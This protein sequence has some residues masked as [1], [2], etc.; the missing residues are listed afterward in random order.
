MILGKLYP[1]YPLVTTDEN[2]SSPDI[3]GYLEHEV[4]LLVLENLQ[5]DKPLVNQIKLQEK[6]VKDKNEKKTS[7]AWSF[8]LDYYWNFVVARHHSKSEEDSLLQTLEM[9][10]RDLQLDSGRCDQLKIVEVVTFDHYKTTKICTLTFTEAFWAIHELKMAQG[11]TNV[12]GAKEVLDN[13]RNYCYFVLRPLIAQQVEARMKEFCRELE[14]QCGSNFLD[15]DPFVDGGDPALRLKLV[16]AF[17]IVKKDKVT[18]TKL[19]MLVI[20]QFAHRFIS[21][22][23]SYRVSQCGSYLHSS[24][25]GVCDCKELHPS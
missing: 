8:K 16:E 1:L 11:P 10:L 3:R 6:K 2:E 19:V 13:I 17:L 9:S 14:H 23:C 21:Y 20:I 18:L 22:S 12:S 24:N 5:L 25:V 4:E 15:K 7:L